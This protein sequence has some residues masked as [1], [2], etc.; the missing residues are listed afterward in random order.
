MEAEP[1]SS[2]KWMSI[3]VAFSVRVMLVAGRLMHKTS[4]LVAILIISIIIIIII[5]PI[6]ISCRLGL[7]HGKNM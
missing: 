5:I 4:N 1:R 2:G 6:P 3:M 7:E